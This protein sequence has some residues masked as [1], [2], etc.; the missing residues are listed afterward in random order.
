MLRAKDT[1]SAQ[2]LSGRPWRRAIAVV[3]VWVVAV[4]LAALLLTLGV[5]RLLRA[6]GIE[7]QVPDQA[8]RG[9]R[10][11][12]EKLARYAEERRRRD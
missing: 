4:L 5:E 2:P 1:R 12:L 10:D 8:S 9:M 3:I 6:L 11:V 7:R